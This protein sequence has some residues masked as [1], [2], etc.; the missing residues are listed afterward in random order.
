MSKEAN[1]ANFNMLLL[2]TKQLEDFALFFQAV[3]NKYNS[4]SDQAEKELIEN[5]K[6]TVQEAIELK[7]IIDNFKEQRTLE[8][9]NE[10]DKRLIISI[11]AILMGYSKDKIVKREKD[12][13][14]VKISE[15]A[16]KEF[17]THF[18]LFKQKNQKVYFGDIEFDTTEEAFHFL[19]NKLLHGEYIV[20]NGS[21]II[22]SNNKKASI[23]YTKLLE[24]TKNYEDLSMCNDKEYTRFELMCE[25]PVLHIMAKKGSYSNLDF[26]KNLIVGINLNFK[27]KGSRVHNLKTIKICKAFIEEFKKINSEKGYIIGI[28]GAYKVAIKKYGAVLESNKITPEFSRE[29]YFV[30][31]N[32]ATAI[33]KNDNYIRR[34]T[35]DMTLEIIQQLIDDFAN[36]TTTSP[37]FHLLS[38][39]D[40][41]TT[42]SI[43]FSQKETREGTTYTDPKTGIALLKFYTSIIYPSEN[44]LWNGSSTEITDVFDG[45]VLDF[46]KLDLSKFTSIGPV[47]NEKTWSSFESKKKEITK[48]YNIKKS[49]YQKLLQNL[50]DQL[51]KGNTNKQSIEKIT[52][53]VNYAKG[54]YEKA[55]SYKEKLDSFDYDKFM[56]NLNIIFHIRNIIAHGNYQIVPIIYPDGVIEY[57][58]QGEDKINGITTYTI[59]VPIEELYNLSN[60]VREVMGIKDDEEHLNKIKNDTYRSELLKATFVDNNKKEEWE[61]L[62][63]NCYSNKDYEK[64]NTL[65]IAKEFVEEI[66][67]PFTTQHISFNEYLETIGNSLSRFLTFGAISDCQKEQLLTVSSIS[68]TN[69]KYKE[70]MEIVLYYLDTNSFLYRIIHSEEFEKNYEEDSFIKK[71]IEEH[72][73]S[74]KK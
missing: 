64:L 11:A 9:S 48:N 63:N 52:A 68:I 18:H 30:N 51:K 5:N 24:Y 61:N 50:N 43:Q 27:M 42:S 12:Q 19:R 22:N 1:Q 36:K 65:R 31:Q 39:I 15:T 23:K 49:K 55:L 6:Y 25:Y 56:E 35:N 46:S 45:K 14:T 13:T 53:L 26:Y 38:L 28:D 20:E 59:N 16:F 57:N 47:S 4:L 60:Q 58:I 71:M 33:S 32:I 73:K 7:D 8:H 37:T 54:E 74:R 21:I 10:L 41:I 2:A 29:T 62:I 66:E 17:N 44:I 72:N 70:I 34:E 3:I 69:T 40:L 67:E